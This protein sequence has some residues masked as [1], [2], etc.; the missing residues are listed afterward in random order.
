MK[1]KLIFLALALCLVLTGC[2]WMDGY[3]VHVTPHEEKDKRPQFDSVTASSPGELKNILEDM[4][5]EGSSSGVILLTDYDRQ[6]AE[7]NME[8][9]SRYLIHGFPV[10]AYAVES[11]NY[12]IGASSGRPAIAV[13]IH[14]RHNPLEIR[15]IVHVKDMEGMIRE[16]ETALDRIDPGL[17][18]QVEQYEDT[19]FTQIVRDYAWEHPDLVMELP[20][21]TTALYGSSAHN[22]VVELKF[23]YLTGRDSL[24]QMRRQVQSVFEAAELYVT[25]DATQHQQYSQLYS[26]LMERFDYRIQTSITPTY[27]LLHHGVG[28]SKAFALTYAAMCKNAGL[29][30]RVVTGTRDGEPW[31][32]NMI[33]ED[34]SCRHV[35]LLRCSTTGGFS[36]KLDGEMEGYVWDY[37]AYPPCNGGV[38][39][40]AET[41][42]P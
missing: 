40:A 6:D 38:E 25:E 34:G 5:M 19:D 35:D 36:H 26:F 1:H 9:M 30:C 11:V 17:V 21:V 29:E 23:T 4:V 32:W 8:V 14:Y 18:I 22:R 24:R 37:S 7:A 28:D 12:E 3:Y 16:V 10:G 13:T 27:S 31:T 42:E 15:Q 39:S 33:V 41:E 2:A 20:Q